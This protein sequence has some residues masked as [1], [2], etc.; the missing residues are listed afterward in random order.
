MV[1]AIQSYHVIIYEQWCN[2]RTNKVGGE[3]AQTAPQAK[4]PIPEVSAHTRSHVWVNV[5]VF[6]DSRFD[7][8]EYFVLV[9]N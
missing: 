7:P 3:H 8:V 6:K 1:V 5:E 2:D 4:S 9:Q